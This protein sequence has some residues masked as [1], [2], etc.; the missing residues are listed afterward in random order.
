MKLDEAKELLKKNGYL[1]ESDNYVE[2]FTEEVIEPLNN[3]IDGLKFIANIGGEVA[4]VDIEQIVNDLSDI[5]DKCED[6]K[7][8]LRAFKIKG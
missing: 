4:P 8:L 1:V 7:K 2:D 5:V 3:I 6:T